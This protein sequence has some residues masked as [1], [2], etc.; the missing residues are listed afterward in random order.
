MDPD[1]IAEIGALVGLSLLGG[2]GLTAGFYLFNKPERYFLGRPKKLN[3]KGQLS[4]KEITSVLKNTELTAPEFSN[5]N[6]EKDN[7]YL[8]LNLTRE[9]DRNS[10]VENHRALRS[11]FK[12][13]GKRYEHL[14]VHDGDFD[15]LPSCVIYLAARSVPS[16]RYCMAK[17]AGQFK[18]ELDGL[19]N[20]LINASL[21]SRIIGPTNNLEMVEQYGDNLEL[22]KVVDR[23]YRS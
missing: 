20:D 5:D 10:F 8:W 21:E 7:W 3:Q 9:E 11:Q 16:S 4:G 15:P 2:A 23:R 18:P 1:T 22:K 14:Q 12:E 19:K 13:Y 6:N 17:T